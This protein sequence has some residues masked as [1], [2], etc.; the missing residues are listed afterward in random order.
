MTKQAQVGAFALLALLLL[1]G[2]FYVI[3]DFGTRHT[4]YKIGVHFQSAAGL[5]PA[6]LVYFSGVT[7]GSVDSITLQPDST[8]DVILAIRNDVDI[9]RESKFIIQAP[10]TGDPDLVIV[11]PV[12]K[13]RPAGI[14]GATPAPS[15]VAMLDRQVLPVDQQPQGINSATL[16]DLLEQGQGEVKR[17]DAMLAD[18]ERREPALLASLQQTMDNANQLTVT[19][20]RSVQTLSAQVQE[21]A[22]TMQAS[23][24]QAS[25]NIVALTGTL[26]DSATVDSRHIHDILASF[27]DTS[28]RLNTSVAALQQIATD[29]S[30]RPTVLD[31]TKQ[32]DATMHNIADLTHDLR[33]FT[34]DPQTQA[35]LKNTVSNL[36][37]TMQR[38]NSLMGALGGT[39][40]V[41]GVD[42]NAT[43]LPT[44]N[45]SAT[46]TP[47]PEGG[48]QPAGQNGT[49]SE[50]TPGEARRMQLKSRLSQIAAGLAQI[51][52]RMSGLSA[53][54]VTGGTPLLSNDRGPQTDINALVFP[55]SSTSFLVGAND[56]DYNGTVNAAITQ[57]LGNNIRVGGGVLYSRLGVLGS[58]NPGVFGVEGRFYDP[59]K[60]T[61]DLYG[62]FNLT[63]SAKLFIG[64]RAINQQQRRTTYGLQF[65]YP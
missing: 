4:G 22:S 55:H 61:L 44:L 11:P 14:V 51:Q 2:V 19:A 42:P 47:V 35:Q 56:I 8:V 3:T 20:N 48:A 21:M 64:E 30:L 29:P 40:S 59:R 32:I 60:P 62:N 49:P 1:F 26:N 15:A 39:S 54:K 10:L 23:L 9:P 13:P 34:G 16:S 45:P 63:K 37:A 58:Y 17:L 27:S 7:V 65:T 46:P 6:A 57:S 50:M 24:N 41:Y 5:R 31:T 18:L 43:P 38:V 52:I 12:P 28:R 25:S 33:N 36:D 53:Q